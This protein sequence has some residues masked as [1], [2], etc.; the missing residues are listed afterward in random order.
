MINKGLYPF[1]IPTIGSYG[2]NKQGTCEK[3]V[4]EIPETETDILNG[5]IV[6][7]SVDSSWSTWGT[8]LN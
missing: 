7:W 8:L 2:W 1:R 5:K 3:N 4:D 6:K